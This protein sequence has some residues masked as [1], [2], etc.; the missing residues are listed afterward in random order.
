MHLQVQSVDLATVWKCV[1]F[2][3]W[4]GVV[5]KSQGFEWCCACVV[6]KSVPLS[7]RPNIALSLHVQRHKN[8]FET[9][10]IYR[11]L[12]CQLRWPLVVCIDP[13]DNLVKDLLSA[14]TRAASVPEG[15]S[16]AKSQGSDS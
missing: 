10:P 6:R 3:L 15:A 1:R 13:P 16:L 9:S 12:T 14:E 8:D 7:R 11:R 2:V 4:I 5:F